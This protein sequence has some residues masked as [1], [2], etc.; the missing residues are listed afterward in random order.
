MRHCNSRGRGFRGQGFEQFFGSHGEVGETGFFA[1]GRHSAGRGGFGGGPFGGKH[2]GGGPGGHGHGHGPGGGGFFDRIADVA[3]MRGGRVL[4]SDDLQLVILALVEEKPR[5][6]YEIIKSLAEKS[7]GIYKPSPGMIYPALTY[8]EEADYVV[9]STEGAK[10]QISLTVE[11]KGFL[12]ENRAHVTAILERLQEYGEKMSYFQQQ[13]N[14]EQEAEE[15]WGGSPKEQQKKE[16]RE[17]KD[18]FRD[19]RHEL[20]AALFEKFSAPLEEKK[21]VLTVLKNAINEI[22]K[23]K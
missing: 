20:K 1:G 16:W 11:G 13:M 2:R 6:G 7:S 22:R 23:A 21:R 17:I 15:K 19:V 5:H 12:E 10:K 9:S 4:T 14:Q 8:L 18:E 3:R